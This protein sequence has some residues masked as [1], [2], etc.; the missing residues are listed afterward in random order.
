MTGSQRLS[1]RALRSLWPRRAIEWN[2]PERERQ[3]S[4]YVQFAVHNT[5][6]F[7]MESMI[8]S[9]VNSGKSSS[10]AISPTLLSAGTRDT[11]F[12]E[13]PGARADLPRLVADPRTIPF[14]PSCNDWSR[15][16]MDLVLAARMLEGLRGKRTGDELNI[17]AALNPTL[18]GVLHRRPLLRVIYRVSTHCQLPPSSKY[19]PSGHGASLVNRLHC[20]G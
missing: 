7:R 15:H 10:V 13:G 4:S 12:H 16:F 18:A 3:W 2:S 11:Q 1:P 14:F 9:L 17:H 6:M 8:F 20:C 19:A 5:S